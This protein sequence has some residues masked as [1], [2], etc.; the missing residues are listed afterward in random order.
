[1]RNWSAVPRPI[2]SPSR[3]VT[4]KVKLP[5]PLTVPVPRYCAFAPET[6]SHSYLALWKLRFPARDWNSV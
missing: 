4:W 1:M 6:T 3:T 5:L 2:M